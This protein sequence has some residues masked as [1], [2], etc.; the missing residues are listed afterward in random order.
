MVVTAI[1]TGHLSA[2]I[3]E[4][5]LDLS[6]DEIAFTNSGQS[7][8]GRCE[9][10]E[11]VSIEVAPT[12]MAEVIAEIGQVYATTEMV[13]RTASGHDEAIMAAARAMAGEVSID[14][15]GQAAMIDALG[16]QLA[17]QL[18]R[19]HLAVRRSSSIELSRAG[20]VDRR[21]RRAIEF[22]HDNYSREL[23]VEEIASAAYLSEYHFA[24]LFKRI[25]GLTPHAYLANL[26]LERARALLVETALPISE[27]AAT[28]GYQSQSH[29]TKA[30]KSVTGVT[31]RAFRGS[32]Q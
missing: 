20:P 32:G 16:H 29:F 18:L 1:L 23:S 17:V 5:E 3:G 26:R 27:I 14:K 13:F 12:L 22:M 6:V 30:F 11:L 15:L 8:A 2:T 7:H 28:V 25:T 24:H 21:L 4:T 31:P 9:N 10:V 19:S